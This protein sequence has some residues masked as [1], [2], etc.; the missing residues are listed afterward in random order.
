MKLFRKV[1]KWGGCIVLAV[2][3]V[4]TV[5]ICV[6][7][8]APAKRPDL[9]TPLPDGVPAPPHGYPS[10]ITSFLAGY[11]FYDII[12][13]ENAPPAPGVVMKSDILY[14]TADG[15][16]LYLDLYSP[17]SAQGAVPGIVL[18]YGGSWKGGRKDQLRVYAQY[19]A[20]HG[21]VVATPQY[22]LKEE[23][24]W[25]R[26][27]Q[28]AKCAVRWM[29]AHAAENGVDPKRIGVMGN[30]A[31]A[32]LALMAGYTSGVEEFEGN[33]G[34]QDQSSAVQAVADV[35]GPTDFTDAGSRDHPSLRAYMGGSYDEDPSRYE[36]A[37]PVRYVT[38]KSPPTCVIHG[39]VDML[40]PVHQSDW[41]VEKLKEK[42]VPHYYSRINGWPHAMDAVEAVN[43]H[44]KALL[45]N[46]FDRYLKGTDTVK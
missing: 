36:K 28:D 15:V 20:Q 7:G 23:G 29:R 17:E 18:F 11:L 5:S 24:R 3:I 25:P 45:V 21:Y 14:A 2:V 38:E 30:S 33:G 34:W 27:V 16:Q 44:T 35:Y 1:L 41:L 43:K 22:R 8:H 40:V 39:T 26:S 31:G 4:A 37:S 32:Y 19:F 10:E 13:L 12:P 42:G 9:V 6:Y 46:F